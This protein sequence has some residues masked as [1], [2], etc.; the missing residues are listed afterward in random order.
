MVAQME[1]P[2]KLLR[3]NGF[4]N[5]FYSIGNKNNGSNKA[6]NDIL[7]KFIDKGLINVSSGEYGDT[8]LTF[9]GDVEKVYDTI[10]KIQDALEREYE[11]FSV[12]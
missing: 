12:N 5:V 8:S 9:T 3:D 11:T 7:Q 10:I 1:D 4:T 2:N 6:I